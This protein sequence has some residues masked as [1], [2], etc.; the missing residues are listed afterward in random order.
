MKGKGL[1]QLDLFF[2][3]REEVRGLQL[4]DLLLL[5]INDMAKLQIGARLNGVHKLFGERL[6]L[7]HLH[8]KI[9]KLL[10]F[11]SM[12]V[13]DAFQLLFRLL[14]YQ[15]HLIRRFLPQ[16]LKL[17]TLPSFVALQ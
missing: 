11:G 5:R 8:E 9:I 4:L 10:H 17:L 15:S 1:S 6:L 14:P 2:E 16:F 13:G 3:V 7:L 12:Q